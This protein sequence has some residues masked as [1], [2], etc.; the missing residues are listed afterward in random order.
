MMC[1]EL[2]LSRSQG[3]K[4]VA[5]PACVAIVLV[6]VGVSTLSC[7]AP[8]NQYRDIPSGRADF[9]VRL[10][11]GFARPYM[12]FFKSQVTADIFTIDGKE[13]ASGVLIHQDDLRDESFDE[14]FKSADWP[15]PNALHL[16]TSGA[17]R[18]GCDA[19]VVRNDTTDTVAVVHVSASDDVFLVMG[20]P[21][22]ARTQYSLAP[23]A[24]PAGRFL[25]VEVLR[26]ARWQRQ[27]EDIPGGEVEAP[28]VLTVTV[29]PDGI[30]ISGARQSV[31]EPD[32][33]QCPA[34]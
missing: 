17:P 8:S 9:R 1:A 3:P 25:D 7:T 32:A 19:L 14:L 21:S 30:H 31:S 29:V 4:A 26:G 33:G 15:H 27:W 6:A 23:R 34:A 24:D 20:V 5:R 12:V 16:Y 28:M 13:I 18:V 11:G 22:Q 2:S 10:H